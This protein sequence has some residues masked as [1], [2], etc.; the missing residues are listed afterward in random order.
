MTELRLTR[1][2]RAEIEIKRS[3]FIALS[4]PAASVEEARALL[5]DARAEFP[6]ARHHCSAYVVSVPSAQP[7][8]HS[9]DD[10]E[11]SGTA[12][13]PMLDVLTGNELMDVAVVVVRYFGGTLL[14]T[15]GLVRAYSDAV[16]EVLSG[17]PV[18]RRITR[19]L[20]RVTAM[21]ATAGKLEADLRG[22]GFDVVGTEYGPTRA[23]IDVAAGQG[24]AEDVAELSAGAAQVE[25]VGVVVRDVPAGTLPTW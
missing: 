4:R 17:E 15:G 24:F 8:L 16:R 9:S 6:D 23:R 11:P 1:P 12:G 25:V 22:R 21:H 2:G 13:R 14:G 19:P 5:A 3:R 20:M 10:G 18:T 7:I